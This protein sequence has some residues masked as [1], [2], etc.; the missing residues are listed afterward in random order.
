MA[1]EKIL[2]VDDEEEFILTLSERLKSRGYIVDTA[3]TGVEAIKKA[4]PHD[5]PCFIWL[6]A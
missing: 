4:E 3:T 6:K 1:Y 2:L 5:R